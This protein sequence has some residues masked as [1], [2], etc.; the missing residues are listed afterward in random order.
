MIEQHALAA[1]FFGAMHSMYPES[2]HHF[3]EP[4]AVTEARYH[5]FAEDIAQVVLDPRVKPLF[6][7]EYGQIKTGLL[8]ISLAYFETSYRQ[9]FFDCTRTGDHGLSFG[10]FQTQRYPDTTCQGTVQAAWV[11]IDMIHESFEICHGL[12]DIQYRLAEYTDGNG[13]NTKRAKDR[14]FYRMNKAMYYFY[15]HPFTS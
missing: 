1:Y 2:N 8:L 5:Q 9:D 13:W 14:S 12:P 6:K 10:P 11:A 15:A 4:Q 7:G 3:Y